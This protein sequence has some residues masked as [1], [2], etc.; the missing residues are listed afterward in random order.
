[1]ATKMGLGMYVKMARDELES[2][3]WRDLTKQDMDEIEDKIN[4][5]IK[6]FEDNHNLYIQMSETNPTIIRGIKFT[7][8]M[9]G[10][11]VDKNSI[12]GNYY[13]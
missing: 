5:L 13:T 1:M 8:N 3:M 11:I 12:K 2:Y 10:D 4:K 6:K 7:Y 9:N